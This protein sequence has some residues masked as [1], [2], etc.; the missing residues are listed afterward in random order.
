ML[1]WYQ[2][3]S[4]K[5]DREC[6][7]TISVREGTC[8]RDH[9][10]SKH[11]ARAAR[12]CITCLR[13]YGCLNEGVPFARTNSSSLKCLPTQRFLE[14]ESWSCKAVRRPS[15]CRHVP[16]AFPNCI[17]QLILESYWLNNPTWPPRCGAIQ[18]FF[19]N[20]PNLQ[21]PNKYPWFSIRVVSWTLC[22]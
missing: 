1:A 12:P 14:S 20:G 2:R 10:G 18:H 3:A 11:I 9:A 13:V 16:L 7:S 19:F 22:A 5:N 15:T 21:H 6:A 8:P 17:M 4:A